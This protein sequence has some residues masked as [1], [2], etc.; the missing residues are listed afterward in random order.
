MLDMYRQLDKLLAACDRLIPIALQKNGK[1]GSQP[2]CFQASDIVY[3]KADQTPY[4]A[5]NSLPPGNPDQSLCE[6]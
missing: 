2:G 3:I 5:G 4:R 6:I 1:A